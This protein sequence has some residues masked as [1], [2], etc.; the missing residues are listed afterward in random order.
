VRPNPALYIVAVGVGIALLPLPYGY[1]QVMRWVVAASCAWLA[2]SAHRSG[3]EGWVWC[4][5]VIAGVY[6]PI[7]PVHASRG[8]WS[9]VNLATIVIAVWYGVKLTKQNRGARNG[10]ET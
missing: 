7:V 9:V 10:G 5:A 4:W 3:H 8:V 2:V 6:N 1:Y